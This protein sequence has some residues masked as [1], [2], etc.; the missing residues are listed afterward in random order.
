M[1]PTC[2]SGYRVEIVFN[3]VLHKKDEALLELI[4]S[5]FNVGKIYK[6]SQYGL[7]LQVE[8]VKE[9]E[10]I[11]K[12]FDLYPLITQKWSDYS[13]IKEAFL[14]VKK[15]RTFNSRWF[16]KNCSDQSFNE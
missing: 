13:L 16:K 9:F 4:K 5:Y 11:I 8:S 6:V 10:A 12:H 2:K 1:S 15:K 7:R 14:I 3:I